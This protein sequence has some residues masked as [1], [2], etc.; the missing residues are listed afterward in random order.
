[1]NK[2]LSLALSLLFVVAVVSCSGSDE[3][4]EGTKQDTKTDFRQSIWGMAPD[5]EKSTE[6]GTP[7]SENN[8]VILYKTDYIYACS[9]RLCFKKGALFKGAYLFEELFDNP[10]DYVVAYEKIRLPS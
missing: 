1:L 8:N 4:I 5:H 6:V 10:D 7:L 9:G 3:D 2:L